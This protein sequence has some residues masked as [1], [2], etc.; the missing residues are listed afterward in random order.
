MQFLKDNPNKV[1]VFADFETCHLNLLENNLPWSLSFILYQN[2][3]IL[4]THN[5]YI[6]WDNLPISEGA[7]RVTRFDKNVYNEKAEDPIK[8]LDKFETYISNEDLIINFHNAMNFDIYILN[9]I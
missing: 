9:I 2:G 8:I 4:E 5:H 1:L 6:K 7:A 3:K